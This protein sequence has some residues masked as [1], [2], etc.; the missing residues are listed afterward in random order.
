MTATGAQALTPLPPCDGQEGGMNVYGASMFG[1]AQSGFVFET[2]H[3]LDSADGIIA[4]ADGPVD[5]LNQFM[6]IRITQCRTGKFIAVKNAPAYRSIDPLLATEFLRNR[7]QREE[8]F[9]FVD[10]KRAA[11]ALYAKGGFSEVIILRETEE[12]CACN[13]HYPGVWN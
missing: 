9:R 12:T 2:Y 13:V 8:P 5:A 11:T 10:V 3:S 7:T 1:H 6:G 4:G